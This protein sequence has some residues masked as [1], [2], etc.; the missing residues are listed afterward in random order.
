MKWTRMMMVTTSKNNTTTYKKWQVKTK[1]EDDK[2]GEGRGK[3]KVT[4]QITKQQ[5][6]KLTKDKTQ[7]T[8]K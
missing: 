4:M 6:N 5:C 8:K 7:K 3:K 2:I 1:R